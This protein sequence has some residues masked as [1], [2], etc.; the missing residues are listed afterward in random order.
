MRTKFAFIAARASEH[1]IRFMC[2][3]I[4]VKSGE[5]SGTHMLDVTETKEGRDCHHKP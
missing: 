3:I 2:R 5:T 4:G 1:A